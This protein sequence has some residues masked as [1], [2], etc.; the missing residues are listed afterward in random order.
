MMLPSRQRVD[1]ASQAGEARRAVDALC[2]A[3]GFGELRTAQAALVVTELATNLVKHTLGAGGELVFTPLLQADAIGLEILSLDRGPGIINVALCLRDGH[4]SAGSAGTGLGAIRRLS[5]SFDIFSAPGQGTAVLSRLWRDAPPAVSQAL[6]LG[7]VCLPVTGE[8]ANGDA[9]A[10]RQGPLSTRFLLVDGLGHGP[11]AAAASALAVSLF[12]HHAHRRP[13]DLLQL[14]HA[15]LRNSRGAAVALADCVAAT[16]L[17]YFVG[18]GNLSG[19]LLGAGRNLHMLSHNGTVGVVARK[20]QV[21]SYPWPAG[22]LMVL[23]SDGLATHWSLAS[24]P[25]LADRDPALIAGVL[26]RDH[27]RPRDD[28]TV[29]VAR[30]AASNTVH[31]AGAAP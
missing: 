27:Q 15:G 22:G 19:L 4:S 6:A 14:I 25:G 31:G 12:E 18:V 16:G 20:I 5:S 29:V 2:R 21:H 11:D 7:A 17:V 9:W 24:Y 3:L 8:A 10:V 30:V 26:Y 23:H 1:D 13:E 28:C